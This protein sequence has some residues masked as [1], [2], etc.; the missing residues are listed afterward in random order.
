MITIKVFLWSPTVHLR[1]L[2]LLIGYGHYSPYL[3]LALGIIIPLEVTQAI[4]ILLLTPISLTCQQML[5]TENGW[6]KDRKRPRQFT[7]GY[8]EYFRIKVSFDS[9]ALTFVIKQNFSLKV[10]LNIYLHAGLLKW[11]RI[12]ITWHEHNHLISNES[13]QRTEQARPWRQIYHFSCYGITS[14]FLCFIHVFLVS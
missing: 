1:S 12:S 7:F 11:P 6:Q 5:L 9:F 13:E 8:T 2:F 3:V 14:Q 4:H 10:I